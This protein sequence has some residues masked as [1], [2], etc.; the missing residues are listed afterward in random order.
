MSKANNAT[1][2]QVYS[3][4]LNLQNYINQS[5]AF[6]RFEK[7]LHE[8]LALQFRQRLNKQ[9]SSVHRA[10]HYLHPANIQKPL[11]ILK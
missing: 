6:S 10:V 8:Y 3:P 4:W 1:V 9:L 11:D 7:D 5:N 2:N